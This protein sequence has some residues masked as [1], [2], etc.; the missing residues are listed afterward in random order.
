[1][2][3]VDISPCTQTAVQRVTTNGSGFT[4]SGLHLW[5]VSQYSAIVECFIRCQGNGKTYGNRASIMSVWTA[6]HSMIRPCD[7]VDL[8][9]CVFAAHIAGYTQVQLLCVCLCMCVSEREQ[10]CVCA[11][12][13]V[14]LLVPQLAMCRFEYFLNILSAHTTL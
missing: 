6:T 8:C 10:K 4:D 2:T 5:H 3:A 1:M 14:R 9:V 13:Y 7:C 11:C 12:V